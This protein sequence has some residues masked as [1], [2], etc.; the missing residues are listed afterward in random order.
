MNDKQVDR[1]L[2]NAQKVFVDELKGKIDEMEELLR[3]CED[4]CTESD[5]RS[6]ERFFHSVNGTASTLGLHYLSSIGR[7]WEV[8]LK[9][10]AE[11]GDK[12][13]KVVLRDAYEAIS[14]IKKKIGHMSAKNKATG[15]LAESC[16]YVNMPDRGKILLIDDE[17]QY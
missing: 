14:I 15:T 4:H 13:D 6:M 17:L 9:D 16:D 2:E 11:R 7:E 12:P 5:A 1:L 10:I 8:K 3:N